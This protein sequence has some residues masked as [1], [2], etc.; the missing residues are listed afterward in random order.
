MFDLDIHIRL[1][2]EMEITLASFY[3]PEDAHIVIEFASCLSP[4]CLLGWMELDT[5]FKERFHESI[6]ELSQRC[7]SLLKYERMHLIDAVY[8]FIASGKRAYYD[9]MLTHNF[10]LSK[11]KCLALWRERKQ[12]RVLILCFLFGVF[13]SDC[14]QMVLDSCL[15]RSPVRIWMWVRNTWP[16]EAFNLLPRVNTTR[17]VELAIGRLNNV[18]LES[19]L[20]VMIPLMVENPRENRFILDLANRNNA[21]KRLISEWEVPEPPSYNQAGPSDTTTEK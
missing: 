18:A 1:A 8:W 13:P 20:S 12:P 14:E 15:G 4:R 16:S 7:V 17:V 10:R 9:Y 6:K 21:V 19:A 2:R 5:E 11:K 3:N